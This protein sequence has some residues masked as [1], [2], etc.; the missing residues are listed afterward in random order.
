MARILVL[1]DEEDICN[2]VRRVLSGSG[3]EVVTFTRAGE[4]LQ[5]LQSHRPDLALLDFKL[6]ESD[7]LV[8]L[9]YLRRHCPGV[10][11]IMITGQPSPEIK[12]KAAELGL[13][14]YL[15]KPLE[16]SV[17]EEQVNRSLG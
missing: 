8:V 3:H 14:D 7:G 6:R 2:L 5:W 9:A 10:K 13:E 12:E 11:A 17:L 1:D 16:I 4:A 15:L